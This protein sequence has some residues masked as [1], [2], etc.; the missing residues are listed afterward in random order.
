[1]VS[2]IISFCGNCGCQLPMGLGHKAPEYQICDNCLRNVSDRSA[3]C[4]G[5]FSAEDG[6]KLLALVG[7]SYP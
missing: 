5:T 3:R 1:M 6:K 4:E 2:F 7:E